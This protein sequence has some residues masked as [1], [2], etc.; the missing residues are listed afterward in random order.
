MSLSDGNPDKGP[1][2]YGS[3]ELCDLCDGTGDYGEWY[4]PECKGSGVVWDEVEDDEWA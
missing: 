3:V 2:S 4:C 1:P